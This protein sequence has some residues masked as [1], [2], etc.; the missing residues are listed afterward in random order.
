MADPSTEG[1]GHNQSFEAERLQQWLG[2]P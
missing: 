2:A 1:F